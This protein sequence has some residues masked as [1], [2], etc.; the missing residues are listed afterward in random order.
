MITICSKVRAVV[1]V[2]VWDLGIPSLTLFA[3]SGLGL[4]T[5]ILSA[6]IISELL[7]FLCAL[8]W[9]D[10]PDR[11]TQLFGW[12]I[13][14]S[15]IAPYTL[16]ASVRVTAVTVI[17]VCPINGTYLSFDSRYFR[18]PWQAFF[19]RPC[20]RL[21]ATVVLVVLAYQALITIDTRCFAYGL[22][23]LLPWILRIANKA[24]DRVFRAIGIAAVVMTSNRSIEITVFIPVCRQT[25]CIPWKTR[26]T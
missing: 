11:I 14:V 15:D 23:F 12:T 25:V 22:A 3:R 8:N 20:F 21:A 1:I 2:N 24:P 18:I 16:L 7:V 26:L 9:I 4:A 19:T 17:S 6:D 13:W 10:I 5:S